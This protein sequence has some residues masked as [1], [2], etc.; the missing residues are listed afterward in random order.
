MQNVSAAAAPAAG[1]S[2]FWRCFSGEEAAHTGGSSHGAMPSL[3]ADC[4]EASRPERS[5]GGECAAAAVD[6]NPPLG[7]AI[8]SASKARPNAPLSGFSD[9]WDALPDICGAP[10]CTLPLPLFSPSA[11]LV[12]AGT[13]QALAD[14]LCDGRG[15]A[16][17]DVESRAKT[18]WYGGGM[19]CTGGVGGGGGGGGGDVMR[20]RSQIGI[21]AAACI[22]ALDHIF[23][24]FASASKAVE[25]WRGPE[26]RA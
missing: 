9:G 23:G 24:A 11:H 8:S 26:R 12:R 7:I 10:Q 6:A 13:E 14:L 25:R 2:A 5:E 21:S 3:G 22:Q 17:W 19:G 4:R 16:P 18:G 20:G 1:T 15:E